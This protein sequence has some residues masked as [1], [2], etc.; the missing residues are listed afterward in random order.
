MSTEQARVLFSAMLEGTIPDMELGAILLSLRIK[1]ETAEELTGF[2]LALDE[3]TAQLEVPGGP[4]CVVI[5]TYNGARKQA[6]L[7]PLVALLLA[8]Q[9]VPVLIQGRHDFDTRV[10]PFKLLD[11]LGV[12]TQSSLP[13][14]RHAL[15]EHK[16]ACVRLDQFCRGLDW[17]LSLRQR[18]GV[19][20]CGHTLA[21]LIDPCKGRSVRVIPLTHPAFFETLEAV[22]TA[23]QANA[24]VMRGTEGEAYASPR[25]RPRLLGLHEGVP[26]VLFEQE[27]FASSEFPEE[28]G[29]LA[30]NAKLI[31]S[32]LA[33]Q[34]PVPQAIQDQVSALVEL[35]KQPCAQ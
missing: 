30:A 25:R 6:N 20:N 26:R 3:H 13:E 23:E 31:R 8:R 28:G 10:S 33:G 1:G 22:L 9:G 5:P 21:K 12:P 19:R 35:A 16:I 24:L 7:M 17:V 29:E 34:I 27:E 2:K 32:M 18:L 11:A 14:A 4:R 15:F